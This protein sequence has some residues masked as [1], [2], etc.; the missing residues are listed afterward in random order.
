MRVVMLALENLN[1]NGGFHSGGQTSL[2]APKALYLACNRD[3]KVRGS[4]FMS[5][6]VSLIAGIVGIAS[7]PIIFIN[8]LVSSEVFSFLEGRPI[9]AKSASFSRGICFEKDLL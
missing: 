7:Y 9:K 8:G 1:C 2:T 4:P 6:R 3:T 5:S